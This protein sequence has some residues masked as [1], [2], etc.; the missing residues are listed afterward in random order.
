MT[1]ASFNIELHTL[2]DTERLGQLLGKISQ[3][4]DVIILSGSLGA[5][6]TTITQSIGTGLGVPPNCYITS[7]TFSLMHEY[8][9]RLT[10]YHMDL[11]RLS[12]E[13]EI[14]D[15]GFLE[16]IYGD[17]L[18]VI[19]WPNRLG[20]LMPEEYLEIKLELQDTEDTRTSRISAAGNQWQTRL[21]KIPQMFPG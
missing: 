7:P 2:A 20:S 6:K 15:L 13:E 12:S 18:T 9:G 21:G 4:G 3:A 17:G 16:Y 8:Q 19:E 5:G 10:L 1:A 11:Y 14:E